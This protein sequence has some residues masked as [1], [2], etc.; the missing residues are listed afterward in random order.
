M[1]KTINIII[2]SLTVIIFA[3]SLYIIIGSATAIKNNELFRIFGYSYAVVPTGSMQG[4]GPD[5]FNPGDVV[6]IYNASFEEL[7]IGD[8][9]VFKSEDDSKLIIH[10]IIAGDENGYV[11]KGDN[12]QLQDFGL[13][14][15]DNYRG[16]YQSHF[17]F[18]GIGLWLTDVRTII[19]GGVIVILF[20]SI[21][22]Q[23]FKMIWQVKK[24]KLENY[25]KEL[26]NNKD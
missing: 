2:T 15:V 24:Q 5:N 20:I 14:T 6:L 8:I 4:E 22:Y 13:V 18:F 12:N 25:E 21:I 3:L 1:K 11:T 23:T 9:I 26:E 16:R 19:L 10:R 17:E 7:N